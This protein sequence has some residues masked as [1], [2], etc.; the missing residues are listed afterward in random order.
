MPQEQ[1]RELEHGSSDVSAS[2]ANAPRSVEEA[3]RDPERARN[4]PIPIYP[5]CG[6]PSVL[7]QVCWLLFVVVAPDHPLEHDRVE[8][9]CDRLRDT[10][11]F[12]SAFAQLTL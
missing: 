2:I 3:L 9:P 5:N 12:L 4:G 10:V 8:C 11:R 7:I 1:S 6:S